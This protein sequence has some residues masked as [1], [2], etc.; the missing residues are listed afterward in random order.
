MIKPDSK[1]FGMGY[2]NFDFS[3]NLKTNNEGSFFSYLLLMKMVTISISF[4]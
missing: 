2:T 4:D 1:S 3:K